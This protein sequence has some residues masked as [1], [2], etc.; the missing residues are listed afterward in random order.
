MDTVGRGIDDDTVGV[1]AR[2]PGEL[3]SD[4]NYNSVVIL[5]TYGTAHALL[6]GDAGAGEEYVA[7]PYRAYTPGDAV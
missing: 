5:L 4:T 6:A 3:F 7:A 1:I 2:S